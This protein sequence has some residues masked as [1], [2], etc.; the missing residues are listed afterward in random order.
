MGA[1]EFRF[2]F[3]AL[4]F[5]PGDGVLLISALVIDAVFG[6]WPTLRR[7]VPHPALIIAVLVGELTRRLNRGQRGPR[8]RLFRGLI[9]VAVVIVLAALAG[10]ALSTLG[11]AVPFAWILIIF[12][13]AGLTV[14]RGPFDEAS[15]VSIGFAKGG[16]AGG[17]EAAGKVIGPEAGA[18]E[19]STL[20]RALLRH[21][22]GRFADGLI[23]G[24]FWFLV[25]GLPG[26]VIYRAINI[27]GRLLDEAKP[28]IGLYGFVP[29]RLNDAVGFLPTWAGGVILTFAALF[30]PGARPFGVLRAMIKGGD[31]ADQ[32]ARGPA[33]GAFGGALGLDLAAGDVSKAS[34]RQGAALSTA[35]I[36][37]GQY[38][39]AVGGLLTFGLI[40]IVATLRL[41][42]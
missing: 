21:L 16:P 35:D 3:D 4:A 6:S 19:P 17:R 38:L 22:A 29:T 7:L 40:T 15:Q 31:K 25:L 8:T 42:I 9:A 18:A 13:I 20:V 24:I 5:G 1:I 27:S 23:G 11:Q 37:R 12:V 36:V 39:Y 33:A 32:Y 41:A 2:D 26:L 14:Q 28:E 10:W 30:V 34:P